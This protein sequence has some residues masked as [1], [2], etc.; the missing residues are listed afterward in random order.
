MNLHEKI[1]AASS[2][3]RAGIRSA[4]QFLLPDSRKSLAVLAIMKN[5]GPNVQEWLDHYFWQ[6]AD[7]IYI[8]D[9]D[10]TDD[11]I[12]KIDASSHRERVTIIS[13]TRRHQQRQHY[14]RA[15][16]HQKIKKKFR[17]L[18]IVDADEFCFSKKHEKVTETLMEL[19]WYELIYIQWTYFGCHDQDKH[20]ASLRSE[21]IFK[22]HE[23]GDHLATKYFVKTHLIKR[24]SIKIHKFRDASSEKTITA[25]D[26]F[27]LNHYQTQSLCF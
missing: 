8:I 4:K 18:L 24:K 10:S 1:Q 20:P 27:Q 23:L 9:N 5:E 14:R 15:I 16:K 13:E 21:L 6:G 22:H 11:M 7:H 26:L 17:W 12:Q 25:N 3:C 2:K 19:D